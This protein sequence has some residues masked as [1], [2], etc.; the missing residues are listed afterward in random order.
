MLDITPLACREDNYIWVAHNATHAMA[1]DPGEA[2]PL[3]DFLEARHLSLAALFITHH[4]GDHCAGVPEITRRHPVPVYASHLSQVAGVTHRVAEGDEIP[5]PD[6][7]HAWQVLGFPGHTLDHLGFYSEAGLFCGDTLFS[8]GCGRLFEG[9]AEQMTNSMEKILALP[10]ETRIW[11]AHEYTLE[12]IPFV[13]KVDPDNPAVT[14]W[15]VRAQQLCK[16]ALPTLPSLLSEEIQVN[17]FLRFREPGIIEAASRYIGKPLGTPVEV[18]A[19]LRHWRDHPRANFY[20][21]TR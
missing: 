6:L 8:C 20:A 16:Q 2:M 21:E 18:F 10:S 3:L 11:S 14:A 5:V 15:L 7:Q 12:N 9:T 13:Q 17:P 19:A 1:V 4:H